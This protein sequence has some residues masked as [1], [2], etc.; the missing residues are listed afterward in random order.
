MYPHATAYV[1]PHVALPCVH[2]GN[3][4]QICEKLGGEESTLVDAIWGKPIPS[5]QDGTMQKQ[6]SELLA[7]RRQILDRQPVSDESE[8]GEDE[9]DGYAPPKDFTTTSGHDRSTFA[10]LPAGVTALVADDMRANRKILKYVFE[11]EFKWRVSESKTAEHVS[12][13]AVLEPRL[14][15]KHRHCLLSSV[16]FCCQPLRRQL[17]CCPVPLLRVR[18]SSASSTGERSTRCS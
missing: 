10:K 6:L 14:L 8:G 13:T 9:V 5:W 17:R 3:S 1:S 15:L 12:T 18:W 2:S 7:K 11:K 16:S 4:D